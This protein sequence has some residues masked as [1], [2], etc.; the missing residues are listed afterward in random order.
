MV[1][2]EQFSLFLSEKDRFGETMGV[3]SFPSTSAEQ[4]SL[5]VAHAENRQLHHHHEMEGGKGDSFVVKV[6]AMEWCYCLRKPVKKLEQDIDAQECCLTLITSKPYNRAR[7]E[8]ATNM[9]LE[10]YMES[11]NPTKMVEAVMNFQAKGSFNGLNLR[12]L[13]FEPR[14]AGNMLELVTDYKMDVI[15][16]LNAVLLKKR[17]LVVGDDTRQTTV[18]METLPQFALHRADLFNTVTRPTV[19]DTTAHLED[20][21]NSGFWIAGVSEAAYANMN[22]SELRA[23]VTINTSEKRIAVAP[24]SVNTMKLCSVHKALTADIL[25]AAEADGATSAQL[26][27]LVHERTQTMLEKLQSVAQDNGGAL[28]EAAIRTEKVGTEAVQNFFVRLAVA[29]G[30]LA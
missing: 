18:A 15:I 12:Q 29:E 1:G 21:Q 13:V 6:G 11:G 3:W 16:L 20:L 24:A 19:L 27:D 4:Q 7:Y 5:L 23:D 2:G 28:T 9:L 8:A 17:I 10:L 26:V 14:N 25:A 22:T 30:A